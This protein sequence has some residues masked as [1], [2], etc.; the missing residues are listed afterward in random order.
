MFHRAVTAT[1]VILGAAAGSAA[2]TADDLVERHLA[3]LGGRAAL[4][5]VTSRTRI[6]A[7]SVSTPAG[8]LNGPIEAT[9]VVPN[10]SRIFIT[11]DVG[12]EP[13]VYDA[14]FDGSSGYVINTSEGNYDVGGNELHNLRNETFPTPLLDYKRQGASLVLSGKEKIDHRE[15]YVLTLTPK[16]GPAITRYIDAESYL[17]I[18]T[19]TMTEDPRGAFELTTDFSDYRDVD[20]IKVPFHVRGSSSARNFTAILTNVKHNQPLDAAMFARPTQ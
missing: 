16:T 8:D 10:K 18:R 20:G 9:S 2:Q 15:A 14:R 19:V 12:A 3:A 7:I 1:A 5:S 13:I 4:E 17:E 6:G 11:F